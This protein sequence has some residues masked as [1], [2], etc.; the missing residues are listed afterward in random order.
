MCLRES[1]SGRMWTW[2]TTTAGVSITT[3][4]LAV[5]MAL[6]T[7]ILR[8]DHI[9][10]LRAILA[11]KSPSEARRLQPSGRAAIIMRIS[12]LQPPV[13]QLAHPPSGGQTR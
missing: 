6:S 13:P 7:E 4:L 5:R 1:G 2:I 10:R 12:A 3:N 9:D 11:A 8:S